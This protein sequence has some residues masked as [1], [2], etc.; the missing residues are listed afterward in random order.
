ML[1]QAEEKRN[2]I[3]KTRIVNDHQARL[4]RMQVLPLRLIRLTAVR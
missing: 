1:L 4:K 3:I 2:Q